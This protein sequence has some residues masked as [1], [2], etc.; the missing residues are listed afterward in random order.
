MITMKTLKQM[1]YISAPSK[2]EQNISLFIQSRLIEMGVE[3]K[4]TENNQIYSFI[5]GTPLLS[6]HMDRVHKKAPDFVFHNGRYMWGT[7]GIGADD[8][9]GCWAILKI[10][11]MRKQEGLPPVSFVF[12]VEE[13]SFGRCI[14]DVLID[15]EHSEKLL[16]GIII[17]RRGASDVICDYNDYGT[18]KFEKAIMDVLSPMGYTACSGSFSDADAISSLMSCCNISCGYYNPHTDM[19]YTDTRQ[20]QHTVS[21]VCAVLKRVDSFFD[22]PEKMYTKY[23]KADAYDYMKYGGTYYNAKPAPK[24]EYIDPIGYCIHC[25]RE[26]YE[27][28]M[29]YD[30]VCPH[31]G[32]EMELYLSR[33]DNDKGDPENGDIIIAEQDSDQDFQRLIREMADNNRDGESKIL[34][35]PPASNKKMSRREKRRVRK[36]K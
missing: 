16:Y 27:G 23:T 6:A 2:K 30:D 7:S 28:D 3:F 13:E 4:T 36:F 18:K 21:A 8:V 11:E 1:Y 24:V 26:V 9:N 17:D 22:A 34:A 25:S 32:S 33:E 20:L 29:V 19:E 5:P 12:S 31:C 15:G 10:L 14:G 35:L